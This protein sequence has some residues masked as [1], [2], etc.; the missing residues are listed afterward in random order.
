MSNRPFAPSVGMIVRRLFRPRD[1]VLR[2]MFRHVFSFGCRALLCELGLAARSVCNPVF[3]LAVNSANAQ[4]ESGL[5][6][7][8][9]IT[10]RID[11]NRLVTLHGNTRPEAKAEYDRGAVSEDF[12]LK[13]MLLQLRRS[14]EQ[15]QALQQFIDE[16]HTKGSPK[17]HRWV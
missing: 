1:A 11:E 15:E 3:L 6:A 9:L 17:Y 8:T 5:H 12:P 13:H 4:V 14:P 7:R 2:A 16:L 10:S